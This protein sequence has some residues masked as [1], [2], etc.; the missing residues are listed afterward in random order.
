[1]IGKLDPT[2]KEVCIIGAG[3]AGLLAAYR[4]SNLNYRVHVYEASVQPGGLIQTSY[5]PFGLVEHAAHSLFINEAVEKLLTELQIPVLNINPDSKARYIVRNGKLRKFP[6]NPNE[7]FS[8]LYSFFTKRSESQTETIQD[9]GNLHLSSTAVDYLLNPML[10]GIYGARPSELLL[11]TVFPK[12]KIPSGKTLFQHYLNL[13]RNKKSKKK[14]QMGVP[15]NGMRSFVNALYEK[16][17]NHPNVSFYFNQETQ[18]L[19]NAKNIILTIPAHQTGKLLSAID[20]ELSKVLEKIEYVPLISANIFL[21][22]NSL[23]KTPK[24]VGV[25]IPEKEQRKVLGILFNSSFNSPGFNNR[26]SDPNY[27]SYT[28]MLGGTLHPELL[29]LSDSEIQQIIEDEFDYFF[30]FRNADEK[31]TAIAWIQINRYSKAIP[32]YNQNLKECLVKAEQTWCSKPGRILFGNYTGQVS[33]RGM[34]ESSAELS[35]PASATLTSSA[36][37]T[38][39]ASPSATTSRPTATT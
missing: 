26:S 9:W 7:V 35:T 22:K 6:L 25:L 23:K 15:A 3:I 12:L 39:T 24:G 18:K 8:L 11:E 19:P 27:D 36:P 1:M 17:S 21:K 32:C 13:R 10:I 31:K 16:L 29:D 30:E 37:T 4:L 20:P 5:S 14:F 34:I 28:V 38:R 33:I 2:S